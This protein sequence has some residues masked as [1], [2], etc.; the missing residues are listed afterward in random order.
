MGTEAQMQKHS[1][2]WVLI[3]LLGSEAGHLE[4]ELSEVT[5]R[6]GVKEA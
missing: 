1:A 5:Q 4:S 6:E 3:L 2:L